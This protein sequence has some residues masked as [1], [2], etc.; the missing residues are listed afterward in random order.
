MR[1]FLKAEGFE[2]FVCGDGRRGMEIFQTRGD[3]DLLIA[4]LQMPHVTG[5]EL[6]L[7]LSTWKRDLPVMIVSGYTRTPEQQLLMEERGWMFFQ[8]PFTVPQMLSAIHELFS[9]AI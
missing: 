9:P 7:G 3:V 1:A 4:D 5:L 8:K 6:A 2:V